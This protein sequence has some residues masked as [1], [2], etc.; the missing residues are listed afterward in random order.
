MRVG[1]VQRFSLLPLARLL[2]RALDRQSQR[3]APKAA[4][5]VVVPVSVVLTLPAPPREL[6]HSPAR[7]LVRP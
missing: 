4:W 6:R 3:R 2:G 5:E 7:A 1:P